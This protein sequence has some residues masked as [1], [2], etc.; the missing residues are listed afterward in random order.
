VD[1][2]AA[3]HGA[4]IR[5]PG[6]V[7]AAAFLLG[8]AALVP[9]SE[10][11]LRDVGVNPTRTAFVS[12][13]ERMGAR[14]TREEERQWTGEPVA[15]L[16]V[17]AG[18][19]GPVRVTASEVPGLIDELPLLAVLA[20]FARGASEIRGAEELRVKESDRIAAMTEGLTRIGVRVEEHPDGWTIHGAGAVRGGS[21]DARGDHRIAMAFLVAG[22][23]AREG[24]AVQGAEAA[25]VSDP[26]FLPRLRRLAR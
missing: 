18:N 15:D 11:R 13:V 8:A 12:L 19:L 6:D 10:L 22:L 1:G 14:V 16:V 26:E 24:V 17:R 4:D 7:S 21:V 25:R 23:R 9:R 5:V 3:L 2:P 20:A